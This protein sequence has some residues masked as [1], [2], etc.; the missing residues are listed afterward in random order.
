MGQQQHAALRRRLL[1]DR[2]N[3]ET[4]EEQAQDAD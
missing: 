2:R 4:R 1:G 3:H